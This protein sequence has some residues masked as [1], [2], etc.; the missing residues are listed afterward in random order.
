MITEETLLPRLDNGSHIN[1]E[2]NLLVWSAAAYQQVI[3]WLGAI[4]HG[5][6]AMLCSS[7]TR[8]SDE[9]GRLP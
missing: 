5:G 7:S 9:G 1:A 3:L 8:A 4:C 6:G 2:D